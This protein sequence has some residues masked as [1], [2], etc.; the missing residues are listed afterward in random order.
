MIFIQL[1]YHTIAVTGDNILL[2]NEWI[3]V[4]RHLNPTTGSTCCQGFTA[5]T[6]PIRTECYIGG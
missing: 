6:T 1:L 5:L 2:M 3:A 4:K